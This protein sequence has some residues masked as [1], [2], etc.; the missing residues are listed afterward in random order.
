MSANS[1]W[2]RFISLRH[3]NHYIGRAFTTP[4]PIDIIKTR[5]KLDKA[6]V[7][8][9]NQNAVIEKACNKPAIDSYKPAR[10]YVTFEKQSDVEICILNTRV[11]PLLVCF[12][13]N[14]L[15]IRHSRTGRL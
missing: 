1:G 8:V 12:S 4:P 15:V 6:I 11:R 2:S 10:V 9:E 13:R 7:K 14:D 3:Y 5:E